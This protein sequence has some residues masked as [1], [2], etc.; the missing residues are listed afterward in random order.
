AAAGNDGSATPVFPAGFPG[1]LGVTATTNQD[2]LA[3]FSNHGLWV[4]LAAPGVGIW[5]TI[6]GNR[7]GKDDGTSMAAPHVT[8]TAAL[9]MAV[10][11]DL[12]AAEVVADLERTEIG[13]AS[14][15]E[16]VEM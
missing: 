6:P 9:M 13:R 1:V 14:G 12:D 8:A 3:G 11:P 7:I 10:A 5:S 16:R 15:R 2:Q 4:P